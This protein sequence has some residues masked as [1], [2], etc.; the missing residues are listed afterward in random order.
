VADLQNE[1]NLYCISISDFELSNPIIV[2]FVN[3]IRFSFC[4][5]LLDKN[6][7]PLRPVIIYPLLNINEDVYRD[8][9]SMNNYE[10]LGNKIVNNLTD[11][12]IYLGGDCDKDCTYCNYM[13][14]Q[15]K[16]CT[17]NKNKLNFNDLLSFLSN[18]RYASVSSVSI[19]SSNLLSY[20]NWNDLLFELQQYP[21][22]KNLYLDCQS[23]LINNDKI[24]QLNNMNYNIMV[25]VNN[26]EYLDRII[27]MA[28]N[29]TKLKFIFA[30][31]NIT[32]LSMILELISKYD[33]N[34]ILIFPYFNG[35]NKLFF[36]KYVY[37]TE[38]DILSSEL[39]RN[40][41]LSN[42]VLNSNYFGKITLFSDGNIY[43][44]ITGEIIG[45]TED[46]INNIIYKEITIGDFWRKTRDKLEPCKQCIFKYLCT[47]PSNYEIALGKNNLCNIR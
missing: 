11:V 20:P 28:M 45:N 17:K 39:S 33:L 22:A 9:N 3:L 12:T 36:E 2:K 31:E 24:I 21:Y 6:S 37:L 23:L 34:N 35:K 5:N 14:K 41:I 15:I 13:F 29:Q 46:S 1:R 4:G 38:D 44:N 47:P 10:R 42:T 32:S 30:I 18:L 40:N 27:Y 19:I 25:L 7:H 8:S 26:L 43:S 16:W